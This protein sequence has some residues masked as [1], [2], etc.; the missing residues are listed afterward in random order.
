MQKQKH[1]AVADSNIALLGSD[2]E[3]KVRVAAAGHEDAWKSVGKVEYVYFGRM[4]R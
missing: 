1:I 2:L 4:A 3:K